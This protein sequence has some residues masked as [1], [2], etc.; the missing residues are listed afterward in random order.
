MPLLPIGNLTE[1]G[2]IPDATPSSLPANAF[3]YSRNYR[4]NQAGYVEV[5]R[6]YNDAYSD[7]LT[8]TSLGANAEATF[9]YSWPRVDNPGVVIYDSNDRL[10]KYVGIEL[11]LIHI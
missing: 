4:Y 5:T 11:S 10:L 1:F 9:F 3:S 8:S 7:L 2:Y 6:G